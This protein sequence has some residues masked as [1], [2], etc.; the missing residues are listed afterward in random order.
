MTS[1]QLVFQGG[2]G[3][4]HTS[5]HRSSFDNEP[6]LDGRPAADGGTYLINGVEWLVRREGTRQRAAVRL[7]PQP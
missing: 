6:H 3:G 4:R 1:F 7:Q 5:M 2:P